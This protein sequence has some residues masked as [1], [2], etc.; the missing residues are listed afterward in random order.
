VPENTI[1]G[2]PFWDEMVRRS[3]FDPDAFSHEI[4]ALH[5]MYTHIL[6]GTGAGNLGAHIF[7]RFAPAFSSDT[8]TNY[9]KTARMR[10]GL[11]LQ[12]PTGA[13]RAQPHGSE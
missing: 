7:S 2:N 11:G 9:C 5:G 1:D 13:R 10:S 3:G 6:V 8:V 12:Q 4:D